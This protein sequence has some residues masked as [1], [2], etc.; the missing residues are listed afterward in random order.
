MPP[1]RS[2]CVCVFFSIFLTKDEASVNTAHISHRGS[3]FWHWKPLDA[4]GEAALK[5]IFGVHDD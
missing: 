1:K 4:T 5:I 3:S 2:V